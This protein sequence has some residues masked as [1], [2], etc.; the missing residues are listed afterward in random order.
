MAALSQQSLSPHWA[1]H[2]K[3]CIGHGSRPRDRSAREPARNWLDDPPRRRAGRA[4]APACRFGLRARARIVYEPP[5]MKIRTYKKSDAKALTSL[6]RALAKYEKMTPPS[7]AAQRRLLAD[8]GRR[9]HVRMAEVDGTCVGYAIYLFSY[10]SFRARPILY[11][12]DLFVLPEHRRTG[13]GGEFFA[14]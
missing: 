3:S 12:E 14:E 10:S 7:P 9:I 4:I 13:L 5:F 6:I 8:I 1:S 2:A 11:L